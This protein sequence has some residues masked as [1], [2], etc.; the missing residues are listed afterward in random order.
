M[1]SPG[2]TP[3]TLQ[4]YTDPVAGEA[5]SWPRLTPTAFPTMNITTLRALPWAAIAYRTS[6]GLRACWIAAQ[7]LTAGLA[8]LAA[9]TWEHRAQIRSAIV[10]VIAALVVATE[11]TYRAGRYARRLW[12]QL[13]DLSERMGRWYASRIAPEPTPAPA[14]EPTPVPAP[15]P[16]PAP[17]VPDLSKLSTRQLRELLGVARHLSKRDLLAMALAA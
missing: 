17:A 10:S 15:A 1:S 4:R 8:I 9:I 3:T 5:L 14:P 6:A 11:A 12:C 13:L 2:T 16:A 7:L